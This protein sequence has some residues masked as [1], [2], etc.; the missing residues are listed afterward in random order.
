VPIV[1]S[2]ISRKA[3]SPVRIKILEYGESGVGV[4]V[5]MVWLVLVPRV[6]QLSAN[7]FVASVIV[8]RD[9]FSAGEAMNEVIDPQAG[10]DIKTAEWNYET[11]REGLDKGIQDIRYVFNSS[12]IGGR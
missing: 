5:G 6:L 9:R 11:N 10:Q 1:N 8:G 3:Y 12:V 2:L 4:I 7:S